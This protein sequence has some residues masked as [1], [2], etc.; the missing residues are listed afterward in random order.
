[1]TDGDDSDRLIALSDSW[2]LRPTGGGGGRWSH[3]E[4]SDDRVATV[5]VHGDDNNSNHHHHVSSASSSR[6]RCARGDDSRDSSTSEASP[7]VG[8]GSKQR[9]SSR[10]SPVIIGKDSSSC[11]EM[12]S[13]RSGDALVVEFSR[14]SAERFSLRGARNALRRGVDNLIGRRTPTSSA[15]NRKQPQ[16]NGSSGR[17][18][19]GD[20]VPVTSEAL[21]RKMERLGCVDL[22]TVDQLDSGVRRPHSSD[23]LLP[24]PRE[25]SP[26]RL[27][28]QLDSTRTTPESVERSS[29]SVAPTNDDWNR[30]FQ[31]CFCDMLE[32]PPALPTVVTTCVDESLNASRQTELDQILDEIVRDIDLLDQTLADSLSE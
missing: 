32:D 3:R 27:S 30:Y 21:Q 4:L 15:V 31:S 29:A 26:G 10:A 6:Q 7:V 23:S 24:G 22:L 9:G 13:Q 19:I 25:V 20:P 16:M 11:G 12:P 2:E 18:E 17:L 8:G 1:V 28:V 14:G 5:P